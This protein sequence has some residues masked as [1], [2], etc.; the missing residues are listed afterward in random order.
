MH[1]SKVF[2]CQVHA[3]RLDGQRAAP[4]G[5]RGALADARA[6]PR[7][8]GRRPAGREIWTW[9]VEKR[10]WPRLPQAATRR[11]AGC[12]RLLDRLIGPFRRGAPPQPQPAT[13]FYTDTTVCIGCKACEVACKQWNQ[14]PADGFDWTGNSYDN[15]GELSATSWRHVKFIEQFADDRPRSRQRRLA[16]DVVPDEPPHNR[17]LMMSDVCK[18]CVDGPLP[19]GVPDRRHHLQRVRERLHPAR[20]LQRLRLLHRGLPVRRHRPQRASTAMPTNARSAT[21]GRSDGLV[22]ACAKACPTAVDPVRPGRRA[23]RAGPQ[24]RGGAAPPRRPAAPTCTATR[25]TDT[26]SE[27]N[28]FYLLVDRPSVYGLPEEPFNPW[29]HMK[30]DYVRA[31]VGGLAAIAVLARGVLPAGALRCAPTPS[32]ATQRPRL[33]GRAGDQ[34]ARLARARRLGHA[35]QQPDDRAVPGR[36]GRRAGRAG[37]LH[38]R[39]EGRLIRSLSSC[40][41]STCCAWCWT[42]ATR[43]ASITCCGCSSPVRPCRSGP[44]V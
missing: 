23:A 12:R 38:A 20:H 42:W 17:W 41:S 36:G 19:A 9:R 43:C 22:P 40:C 44:G 6:G 13:G 14:L 21:T 24:A 18:H 7:H 31:V 3:G 8:A 30:G 32:P 34:G 25:P 16:L 15:T 39:G 35:V 1:E 26:Y 29:L 27:L 37:G 11:A 28:S 10:N 2:A 4:D 5:A 33:R